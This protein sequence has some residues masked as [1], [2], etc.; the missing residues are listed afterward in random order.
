ME[1]IKKMQ[2]KTGMENKK[3]LNGKILILTVFIGFLVFG[4]SQNIKGLAVPRIQ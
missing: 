1:I 4:L 3:D 2:G